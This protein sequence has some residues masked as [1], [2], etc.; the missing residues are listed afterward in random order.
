MPQTT[1]NALP[2]NPTP[3]Q[4]RF[5][6]RLYEQLPMLVVQ[7]TA[8]GV[9]Q[10]CNPEVSRATGYAFGEL[11]GRNFWALLFPGRLFAQVTRFISAVNPNP[12]LRDM[13][14][15]LR[16]KGGQERTIA[17]TRF[18]VPAERSAG[19]DAGEGPPKR[20]LVCVGV[21]LTDRLLDSDKLPNLVVGSGPTVDEG[22]LPGATVQT[23][24]ET[25]AD[26][27]DGTFVIPLAASPPAIQVGED[28]GQAIKDVQECLGQVTERAASLRQT[29]EQ[30]AS[31]PF[32]SLHATGGEDRGGSLRFALAADRMHTL[33]CTG[34]IEQLVQRVD[35]L[36][37]LCKAE[38]RR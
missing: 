23:G 3:E 36:V 29:H 33:D 12:L 25:G 28:G 11:V 15:T 18:F 26:V 17:W 27:L 31:A 35:E 16:T 1:S 34:S 4:V 37:T 22:G 21:D 20:S 10:Q 9:V 7:L 24:A 2:E 32:G 14:L 8:D 5:L 30:S 6:L 38:V 13:P 19:G